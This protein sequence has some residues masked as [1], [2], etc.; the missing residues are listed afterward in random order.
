MFYELA[1][2]CS[3]VLAQTPAGTLHGRN[4]DIGLEVHNITAQVTWRKGGKDLFTSTQFLGYTGVHTGMRLRD[5]SRAAA[6]SRRGRGS[7]GGW[8]V[9]ANERVTLVPGPFIGYKAASALL[10]VSSFGLGATPVGQYLRRALTEH[11]TFDAAMPFLESTHL[12]SPM[13]IIVG[14]A[15]KGQG[16]VLTR[17]RKGVSRSNQFGWP[18]EEKFQGRAG[19]AWRFDTI[20]AP[21]A[22][23]AS[24][25]Q[26][27]C[28]T[29]W[30]F[31]M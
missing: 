11:A 14:G 19:P 15:D 22:A 21:A 6:D 30:D 18:I 27:R 25:F 17:D 9:Q 16:A 1:M 13:Y 26:A 23:P 8:S 20:A 29:N 31:W 2:E 24:A 4:L 5:A 7:D 3:A 28:H 10:T 12:A